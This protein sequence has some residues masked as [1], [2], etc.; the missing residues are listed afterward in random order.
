MRWIMI[1]MLGAGCTED[2]ADV[3]AT[4]V[5]VQLQQDC[6]DCYEQI[7]LYPFCG[8]ALPRIEPDVD[9]VE[10]VTDHAPSEITS[11]VQ[12]QYAGTTVPNAQT[13]L[14]YILAAKETVDV[15]PAF[16]AGTPFLYQFDAAGRVI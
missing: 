2:R 14:D 12:L 4:I 10:A 5:T 15:L 7:D 11:L 13:Q 6:G 9:D 8:D 16:A 3:P 1:A